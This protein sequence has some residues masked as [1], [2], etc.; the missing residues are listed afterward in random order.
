MKKVLKSELSSKYW[1][2]W[3]TFGTFLLKKTPSKL[4]TNSADPRQP[5]AILFPPKAKATMTD[6]SSHTCTCLVRISMTI[7][8][9]RKDVCYGSFLFNSTKKAVKNKSSIYSQLCDGGF[10][11]IPLLQQSTQGKHKHAACLLASILR[12]WLCSS[13]SEMKYLENVVS[14]ILGW[15]KHEVLNRING[16]RLWPSAT[17]EMWKQKKKVTLSTFIHPIQDFVQFIFSVFT[18]VLLPAVPILTAQDHQ[19]SLSPTQSSKMGNLHNHRP[20][21]ATQHIKCTWE[22]GRNRINSHSIQSATKWPGILPVKLER[23]HIILNE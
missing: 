9:F 15:S 8:L 3:F 5:E 19:L 2:G 1:V 17:K 11:F 7:D 14:E 6:I 18:E 21:T 22:R 12:T 20:G 13:V 4:V 10:C 23:F 16:R